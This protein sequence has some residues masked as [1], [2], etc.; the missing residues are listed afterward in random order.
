M[1]EA[2]KSSKDSKKSQAGKTISPPSSSSNLSSLTNSKPQF[3]N[4]KKPVLIDDYHKATKEEQGTTFNL[5]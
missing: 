2:E 4:G 1:A 3:L 5:V